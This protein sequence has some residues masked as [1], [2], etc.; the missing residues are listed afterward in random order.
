ML[1]SANDS[2]F[3]TNGVDGSKYYSIVQQPVTYGYW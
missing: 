2:Y 1:E 3:E